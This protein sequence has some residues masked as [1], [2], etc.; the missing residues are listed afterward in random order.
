MLSS[1]FRSRL[2]IWFTRGIAAVLSNTNVTNKEVQFGRAMPS[3]VVELQSGGRFS[4]EQLFAMNRQSPEFQRRV[5][6]QRF[7][8]QAWALMHYLLFGDPDTEGRERRLNALSSALTAAVP[9]AEA[10][11]SVYGSLATLDAAYRRYVDRNMFRYAVLKTEIQISAKGFAVRP[12]EAGQLAAIRAGYLAASAR[13]VD[14]RSAI[15]QARQLSPNSPASYE[16]EGLLLERETRADEA[17]VAY[18]KAVELKSENFLPYLRLANMLRAQGPEATAARRALIEQSVALNDNFVQGQQALGG[19][20]LQAGLF[21][22][23]L[24]PARRAVELDPTQVSGHTT[25]ANAL[26]RTGKKDEAL[27]ETKIAMSLARS[28][29]ER[30]SVQL[31]IDLIGKIK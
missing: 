30:R 7:D 29:A 31:V 22:E 17:R 27:A 20:L 13:P 24:A 12:V 16:V 5:D 1:A 25:L 11:E 21:T 28:D 9:S 14:A 3:Y 2:P 15:A 4:L 26:A 18:E 19:V 23:A 6:R 8:S 10:V